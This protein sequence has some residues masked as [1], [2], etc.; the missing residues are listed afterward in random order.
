MEARGGGTRERSKQANQH[1]RA[2]IRHPAA[3]LHSKKSSPLNA[4]RGTV[5]RKMR[6][7]E[8]LH[9]GDGT[10]CTGERLRGPSMGQCEP[11]RKFADVQGKATGAWRMQMS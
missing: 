3:G 10:A 6:Q 1:G 5:T 2:E 9:V 8:N 7:R 11:G 4:G